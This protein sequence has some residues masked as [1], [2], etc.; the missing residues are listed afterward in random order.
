[1]KRKLSATVFAICFLLSFQCLAQ[2]N[3]LRLKA[4]KE[5]MELWKQWDG[6]Y[7]MFVHRE[8]KIHKFKDINGMALMVA[9]INSDDIWADAQSF[10]QKSGFKLKFIISNNP[11]MYDKQFLKSPHTIA[12]MVEKVAKYYKF[13]SNNK[14]LRIKFE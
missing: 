11:D 5:I 2:D 6:K 13:D 7:A 8:A 9:W 14:L 10:K 3:V 4:P 1:M 12:I